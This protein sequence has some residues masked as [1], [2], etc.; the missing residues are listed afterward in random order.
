MKGNKRWL[1]GMV[2]FLALLACCVGVLIWQGAVQKQAQEQLLQL[3][4]QTQSGEAPGEPEPQEATVPGQEPQGTESL[5]PEETG[6]T[7]DP[8][9]LL[10]ADVQ[11][12]EENSI[13][14]PEK[15]VDFEDLQANTNADI[16]AW[17]YIPGSKIDYPVLQH[18]TDNSYYLNYN[19]DGSR[20]YPGCIYSEE[21]N[22]KDFA[23]S[24][25][26]LY[27]HNMKNG[28]MFG[29]LHRFEDSAYFEDNPY[30]YIYTPDRLLVY[31]IYAAYEF[32]NLH[33]LL[34]YDTESEYGFGEYLKETLE[35]RD[36]NT[37]IREEI[38]PD[39]QSRILTLSTCVSNKADK[40]YLVQGVLLNEN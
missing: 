18:E 1:A 39:S 6:E 33:L 31:E 21:Y 15:E 37:N 38:F 4:G 13:P 2:L 12:L 36:M 17:I 35:V 40:R 19:L 11:F 28:T 5:A 22:S 34:G 23:D 20:G 26:V 27:G 24:N 3:S 8:A 9:D 32:S 25:T 14:V 30:I 7:A 29:G 10:A 16:Y